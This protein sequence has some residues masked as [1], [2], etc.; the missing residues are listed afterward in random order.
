MEHAK[1]LLD[2]VSEQTDQV[3]TLQQHFCYLLTTVWKSTTRY[4]HRKSP[5]PVRS[6]IFHIPG[7]NRDPVRPKSQKMKFTNLGPMSR[8]VADALDNSQNIPK[9]DRVP[10]FNGKPDSRGV[11][12]LAVTLEFPLGRA[13]DDQS[14]QLPPVISFSINDSEQVVSEHTPVAVAGNHHFRSSKD[15]V[16]CR[17]SLT[18]SAFPT[19]ESKSRP[20]PKSQPSGKHSLSNPETPLKHSRS[21]SRKP[22]MDPN[23]LNLQPPS[24]LPNDLS[25]KFDTEASVSGIGI[26]D[27][28]KMETGHESFDTLPHKYDPGFTLG[29]E[30]RSLSM[31]FT[32]IG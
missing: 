15:I 10:S 8:L 29:L 4:G 19:I 17:F 26:D 1:N 6:G 7:V 5:L 30:D 32:D 20:P 2:I 16:E 24:T 18:P 14:L 21:K 25:S 28:L 12:Q 3:Y 23:D 31:E 22:V 11:G 9:K 13:D 27:F